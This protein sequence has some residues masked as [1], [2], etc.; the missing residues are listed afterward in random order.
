MKNKIKHLI[1]STL[2]GLASTPLSATLL[3][4]YQ[5]DRVELDDVNGDIILTYDNSEQQPVVVRWTTPT[6]FDAQIKLKVER[7]K[8]LIEYKYSIKSDKFSKQR[9]N[10]IFLDA[11]QV[12]ESTVKQPKEWEYLS[13]GEDESIPQD[14]RMTWKSAQE[15]EGIKPSK[16]DKKF[17]FLSKALPSIRYI[18]L[19]GGTFIA[20]YPDSGP[21]I[22][23]RTFIR[24][25]VHKKYM[26]GK[27]YP[28]LAPVI[29][30]QEKAVPADILQSMHDEVENYT[31]YGEMDTVFVDKVNQLL[32]LATNAE[33]SG[34]SKLAYEYLK[35]LKKYIEKEGDDNDVHEHDERKESERNRSTVKKLVKKSLKF[36]INY[37]KKMMKNE[38][39]DD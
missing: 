28:V 19:E 36:N 5:N 9:I 14:E 30:I 31:I 27:N 1:I 2:F 20:S 37:L 12:I 34:D 16:K 3:F 23:T 25:V 22:Q 21:Q 35:D 18:N 6:K 29:K 8:N 4:E 11:K 26:N 32:L 24:D 10:T 13:S 38:D 17:E 7:E 33:K 39:N 15:N